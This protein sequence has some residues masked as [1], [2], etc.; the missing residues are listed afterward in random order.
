MEKRNDNKMQIE[1][2]LRSVVINLETGNREKTGET[3]KLN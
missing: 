2:S 3:S 1:L